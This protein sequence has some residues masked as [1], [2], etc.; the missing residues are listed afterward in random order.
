MAN[1]NSQDTPKTLLV[2]AL[3]S[4][5]ARAIADAALAT[6]Q[7]NNLKPLTVAVLDAGGH[8]MHFHR[9]DGSSILR[10]SIAR[11]KAFGALGLEADSA[12]LGRVAA[13]R[14]QFMA[15]VFA[16]SGGKVVPVPG[17]V[18]VQSEDGRTL[19]AVGISGDISA[20]DEACAVAGIRACGLTCAF[21]RSGKPCVLKSHS[22]PDLKQMVLAL[23]EARQTASRM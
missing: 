2:P 21:A 15:A 22:I 23:E 12:M 17:G 5:Q 4:R 10:E 16:A 14:P 19:G 9:E 7:K 1:T 6:G 13:E 8:L 11:G 18:L 3:S 20:N